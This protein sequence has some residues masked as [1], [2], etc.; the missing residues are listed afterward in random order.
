MLL[1]DAQPVEGGIWMFNECIISCLW[2]P[3]KIMTSIDAETHAPVNFQACFL[4]FSLELKIIG[5]NDAIF[6]RRETFF[7]CC[8]QFAGFNWKQFFFFGWDWTIMIKIA[9]PATHPKTQID[10]QSAITN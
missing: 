1:D 6:G 7:F 9:S 3:I 2:A 5:A 10:H 8:Q 4:K